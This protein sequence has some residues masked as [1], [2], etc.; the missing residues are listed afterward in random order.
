MKVKSKNDS[1]GLKKISLID[2]FNVGGSYNFIADSCK[3]S[4]LQ[5]SLRLK[6]TDNLGL[7]LNADFDPYMYQLDESGNPVKVDDYRWSH[8]K[9]PRLISTSTSFGYT[10]NNQTFKKKDK[11]EQAGET[12]ESADTGEAI[13]P[14]SV[15][16]TKKETRQLDDEGYVKFEMPWSLS[17]D[18]MLRYAQNGEF[19]TEKMQYKLAFFHDLGISGNV[20]LTPKWRISCSA[21][22][23]ITENT[24]TYT[25]VNIT[26]D[27]HCWSMTASIVPIG[28]YTS[29]MFTIRVNASLLQDL[30]YEQR[31]N[32]SPSVW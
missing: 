17:F 2:N 15:F 16:D 12:S 20:S 13:E 18:Y 14:T 10:F 32:S 5:T 26:R 25:S 9:F 31:S 3:L 30:K 23:D 11:K 21:G 27:L 1:I 7:S 24:I 29:Y 22:Y 8:G 19:D 4:N 28:V 6:F